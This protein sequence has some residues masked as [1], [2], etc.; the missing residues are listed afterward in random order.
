MKLEEMLRRV[1]GKWALVSKKDPNKVLQYYR[2]DKDQRPSKKWVSGV[3]QRV[4]AFSENN[5]QLDPIEMLIKK[6]KFTMIDKI[7]ATCGLCGTFALALYRTLKQR[8]LSPSLAAIVL[9]DDAGNHH[10]HHNQ[11]S[12]E[13]TDESELY[14]KHIMVEVNG[15]YYD[16]HG[17]IIDLSATIKKYAWTHGKV[18]TITP[19]ELIQELRTVPNSFSYKHYDKYRKKTLKEAKREKPTLDWFFANQVRNYHIKSEDGLITIYVRAGRR[20]L[21]GQMLKCFDIASITTK[22]RQQRK[23]LFTGWLND[24]EQKIAAMDFDAIYVENVLTPEFCEFWRRRGYTELNDGYNSSF[25]KI[26]ER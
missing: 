24:A 14:W 9:V 10:W 3:E 11:A 21:N 8:G 7:D 1:N 22:E 17:K 16:V 18:I 4:H 26:I 23:G 12:A 2:G 5:S 19:A 25:Y 13:K 15:Q 6:S 20:F